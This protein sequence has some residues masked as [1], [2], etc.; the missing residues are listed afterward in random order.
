MT[1]YPITDKPRAMGRPPLNVTPTLV[2]LTDD[3]RARIEKIAGKNR[4]AGFIR[5]AVEAELTR[6]EE[7]SKRDQKIA[8]N[9]QARKD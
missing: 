1:H 7:A 9:D 6:R 8:K 2:R 5:E 4:M 3:V